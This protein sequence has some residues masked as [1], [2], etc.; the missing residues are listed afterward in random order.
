MVVD[1]A[2]EESCPFRDMY[3]GTLFMPWAH[4]RAHRGCTN[5]LRTLL[6]AMIK[7]GAAIGWET[8]VEH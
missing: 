2:E 5:G 3:T 7:G 6:I 8:E 1:G 4:T